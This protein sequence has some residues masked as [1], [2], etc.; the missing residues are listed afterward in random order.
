MRGERQ[1]QRKTTILRPSYMYK[2]TVSHRIKELS[3]GRKG[4]RH[5]GTET[6]KEKKR[7][8]ER[9]RERETETGGKEMNPASKILQETA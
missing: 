8:R 6:H 2:V 9:E 4:Q 7:E 3:D 5:I 1:R